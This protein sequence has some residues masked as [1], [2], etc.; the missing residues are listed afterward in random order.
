MAASGG[1]ISSL[2]PLSTEVSEIF[3][4]LFTFLVPIELIYTFS[5]HVINSNKN[6]SFFEKYPKLVTW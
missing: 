1:E 4:L 5:F 3:W 6:I 2:S